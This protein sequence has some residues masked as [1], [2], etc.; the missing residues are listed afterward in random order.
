MIVR[1]CEDGQLTTLD[2]MG[3]EENISSD[4]DMRCASNEFTT[5][6]AS[7]RLHRLLTFAN[8]ILVSTRT[9]VFSHLLSDDVSKRSK[10]AFGSSQN[11][12]VVKVLFVESHVPLSKS[13][14]SMIPTI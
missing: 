1:R 6:R 10:G 5:A 13:T 9:F 2:L 11:E 3:L 7:S 14:I 12:P 4:W 8:E